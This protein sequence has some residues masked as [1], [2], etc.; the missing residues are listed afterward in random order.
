MVAAGVLVTKAAVAAVVA[1]AVPIEHHVETNAA[2]A[3]IPVPA[4][5]RVTTTL[6]R[7]IPA[8][9]SVFRRLRI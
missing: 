3:G 5:D 1:A 9:Q 8:G 7:T 6:A 4:A 2:A